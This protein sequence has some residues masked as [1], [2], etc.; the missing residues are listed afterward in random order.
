MGI[1][2]G[3]GRVGRQLLLVGGGIVIG[4]GGWAL[5]QAAPWSGDADAGEQ[6]NAPVIELDARGAATVTTG[7]FGAPQPTGPAAPSPEEAVTRFLSAESTGDYGASWHLLSAADRDVHPT[8]SSWVA[9]HAELPPITGFRMGGTRRADGRAEVSTDTDLRATL[10]EVM[11]L[12][13]ARA[14]GEWTAV[15]EDGGWRVA[16]SDSR[17]LPVYPSDGSAPD[18][19]RRWVERRQACASP[20]PGLEYQGGVLGASYLAESLCLARA[21]GGPGR[22]APASAGDDVTVGRPTRLQADDDAAALLAAFGP[23][24]AEWSRVVPVEGPVPLQAVVA[25]WGSSWLVVGVLT[26]PG[27]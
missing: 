23:Q 5:V 15:A 22:P 8:A 2:S 6:Q 1:G 27:P 12:V 24:V 16:W 3:L 7:S 17:L 20:D 26:P 19:V 14:T 25:P 18:V 4:V 21:A 9:A 13:P 11:G 10:D